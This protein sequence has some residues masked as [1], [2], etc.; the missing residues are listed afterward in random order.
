MALWWQGAVA[1]DAVK[2]PACHEHDWDPFASLYEISPKKSPM[3]PGLRSKSA[4]M[5][6]GIMCIAEWQTNPP[7]VVLPMVH[8][9]VAAHLTA[10]RWPAGIWTCCCAHLQ[11]GSSP[12]SSKQTPAQ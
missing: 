11:M 1:D 7:S 12:S 6:G 10:L 8:H 3:N 2:P 9:R 5:G 4:Q